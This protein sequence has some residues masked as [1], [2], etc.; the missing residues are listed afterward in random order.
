MRD[1]VTTES[2]S[3]RGAVSDDRRVREFEGTPFAA[4]LVGALRRAPQAQAERADI[5]DAQTFGSQDPQIPPLSTSHAKCGWGLNGKTAVRDTPS[6]GTTVAMARDWEGYS[7]AT[8]HLIPA[9]CHDPPNAVSTARCSPQ[10][11]VARRSPPPRT[12]STRSSGRC[13]PPAGRLRRPCGAA[14]G[15]ARLLSGGSDGMLFQNA[16]VRSCDI[17][18]VEFEDAY[19]ARSSTTPSV[20]L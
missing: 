20:R 16:D 13:P 17:P 11:S 15:D 3:V 4:P 14:A 18:P 8:W 5:R 7:L 9:I 6:R 1:E 2:G 10:S 12:S 19:L